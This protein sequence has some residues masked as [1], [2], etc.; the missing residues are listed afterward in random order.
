M[1]FGGVYNRESAPFVLTPSFVH[2][3]GDEAGREYARFRDLSQRAFV[4][5]RRASNL[6][7]NLFQMMLST[8]IPQL[9][10]PSDIE[11]LKSAFC[12]GVSEQ[13]AMARW[14]SLLVESLNTKTTQINFFFHNLA[15]PI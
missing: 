14:A 7:L 8:G 11:Y 5:V 2:V 1:K 15:H 3:M 6:F 10:L 12:L 9:R 4:V 13:E